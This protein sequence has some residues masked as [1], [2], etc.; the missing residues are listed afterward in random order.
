MCKSI[1]SPFPPLAQVLPPSLQLKLVVSLEASTNRKLFLHQSL[2]V[3]LQPQSSQP[4][5]RAMTSN[6]C[7]NVISLEMDQGLRWGGHRRVLTGCASVQR[8]VR[9]RKVKEV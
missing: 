4:P 3:Q 5:E 7:R 1:L 8:V 6:S 2:W 9:D